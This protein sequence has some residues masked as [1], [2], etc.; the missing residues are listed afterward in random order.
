MFLEL[1]DDVHVVR[2]TDEILFFFLNGFSFFLHVWQVASLISL[3]SF[4][5]IYLTIFWV[6]ISF[7]SFHFYYGSIPPIQ[8]Q[9][10]F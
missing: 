9:D 1:S 6:P 7:F 10:F 5:V 8:Y 2:V 3:I 4:F